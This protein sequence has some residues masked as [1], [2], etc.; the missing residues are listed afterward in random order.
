ME[1]TDVQIRLFG[2]K[3]LKA[4]A[5]IVFDHCFV[6]RNL[7]VIKNHKGYIVS[8]PNRKDDS[9]IYRDI[10]HPINENTR[11]MIATRVLDA[12]QIELAQQP[13]LVGLADDLDKEEVFELT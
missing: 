13:A 4:F 7:K 11:K 10:A 2:G 9:G 1:I 8:M 5:T 12:F 6:V 3:K